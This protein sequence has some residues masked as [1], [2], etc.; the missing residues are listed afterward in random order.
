MAR[1]LVYPESVTRSHG[2]QPRGRGRNR[3]S[4]NR[5]QGDP[6]GYREKLI[7]Y[8]PAEATAFFLPAAA[9]L[10]AR[11]T[12]R[13]SWIVVLILGMVIT[14][15]FVGGTVS[16]ENPLPPYYT[17]ILAVAAFIVWS[18]GTTQIGSSLFDNWESA[19]A[20]IAVGAGVFIIPGIDQ[21]VTRRRA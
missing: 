18:F 1:A 6:D 19:I 8:V 3:P 15:L 10:N 4:R 12:G 21:F 20:D 5:H 13:L 14:V 16:T 7:K 17:Y 2:N 9:L 11:D